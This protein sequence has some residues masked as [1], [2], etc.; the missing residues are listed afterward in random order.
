MFYVTQLLIIF[1]FDI[2]TNPGVRKSQIYSKSLLFKFFSETSH[3]NC[4]Q[5]SK[6]FRFCSQLV[7]LDEQR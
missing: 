1:N 6:Y 4:G 2:T 3:V 7:R 5:R